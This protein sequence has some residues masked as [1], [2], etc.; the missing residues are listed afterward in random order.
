[1]VPVPFARNACCSR[2]ANRK[3]DKQIQFWIKQGCTCCHRTC[4]DD[5]KDNMADSFRCPI[6]L[7]SPF[8]TCCLGQ[9]CLTAL[10][11]QDKHASL[12]VIDNVFNKFPDLI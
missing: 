10:G 7:D 4:K 3:T 8:E 9:H 2:L 5:C 12:R 6:Q 11:P 1:M